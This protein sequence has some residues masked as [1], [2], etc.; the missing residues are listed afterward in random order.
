VKAEFDRIS[1]EE[2]RSTVT[3]WAR[4]TWD[5][6]MTLGE[7]WRRLADAGLAVPS[8]PVEWLGRGWAR[9]QAVV[10]HAALAKAGVPGPPVGLG[11]MLAGPTILRHGDDAQKQ[12]I[13][14]TVPH[15]P[16]AVTAGLLR[17]LGQ[18]CKGPTAHGQRR[19]R[20]PAT[21]SP[22]G[23]GGDRRGLEHASPP[24]GDATDRNLPR[25]RD[26]CARSPRWSWPQA[27]PRRDHRR[28]RRRLRWR[29]RET[30]Q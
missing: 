3:N 27:N 6:T 30:L 19:A 7:W 23:E 5:P 17:Q 14:Q 24:A 10:A 13:A 2:I 4:A 8:W 28:S 21:L 12:E 26:P 25:L 29:H 22:C 20:A 9:A 11:V 18:F 16:V 1:D 15:H